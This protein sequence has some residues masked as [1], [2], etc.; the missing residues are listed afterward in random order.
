MTE[1]YIEFEMSDEMKAE[2]NIEELIK[3]SPGVQLLNDSEKI[4]LALLNK[5]LKELPSE[6]EYNY[7]IYTEIERVWV[8]ALK[9][10]I[11]RSDKALRGI[12]PGDYPLK[13]E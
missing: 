12:E 5:M 6:M 2:R 4:Q 13:T 10:S 1:D 9:R 7:R 8:K 3:F 11:K